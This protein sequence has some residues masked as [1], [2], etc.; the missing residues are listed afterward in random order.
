MSDQ[1]TC[2]D[3]GT[4]MTDHFNLFCKTK[5]IFLQLRLQNGIRTKFDCMQLLWM[6]RWHCQPWIATPMV[7]LL[8]EA[9]HTS[10]A[11]AVEF[12]VTKV[13]LSPEQPDK[14]VIRGWCNGHTYI[15]QP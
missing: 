11:S 2:G 4:V 7:G 12:S 13:T 9:Y 14:P 1:K 6:Q 15:A 8:L 3:S 10:P 5:I